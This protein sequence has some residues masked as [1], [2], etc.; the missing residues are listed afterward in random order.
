MSDSRIAALFAELADAGRPAL[1][2][3]IMGGDPSLATTAD[4]LAALPKAGA[5]MIEIGIPFSDPMADGPTIAAAGKRALAAGA[6]LPKILKLV[7][8]FRASNHTTPIILMGYY[9]P[10]YRFGEE[11]FCKQAA[12]AGIDGLILVDL[13]PE[14][15]RELRPH[16]KTH[17]LDLIRL[18]APTTSDRRLKTLMQSAGGFVYYVSITGVT[19]TR[20]ANFASLKRQVAHTRHFTP[21]PIAVGFGIKTPEQVAKVAAFADA[22]VVG[23]ALVEVIHKQKKDR[24]QVVKAASAFVRSLAEAIR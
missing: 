15:E 19:G 12:A 9:N 23:S 18:V 11:A 22:V 24:K 8:A 5:D 10:V 2:P 1:V 14:E 7:K 21:L 13:P 20:S 16:L 17:K 3:F 4:L 6:S